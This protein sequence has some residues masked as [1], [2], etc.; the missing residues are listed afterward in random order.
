MTTIDPSTNLGKLRLR[1]ADVGDLPFLSDVVYT[2]TLTDNDDNLPRCAVILA[3]YILGQLAF[4]THRRMGVQLEVWGKEAFDSY[5]SFLLLTVKDPSFMEVYP[6]A[7]GSASLST[8]HPLIQFQQDWNKN[9]YQGT[10][11]QQLAVDGVNSPNEN[12][13]YGPLGSDSGWQLTGNN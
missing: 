1:I 11:S 5:K 2:Q 6:I 3:T 12:D 7:Y 4:K 13:L 9:Y 10:Q 8:T